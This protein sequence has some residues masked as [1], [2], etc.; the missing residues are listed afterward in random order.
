M[1]LQVGLIG[2]GN[3]SMLGGLVDAHPQAR[4]SAIYDPDPAA[5][6]RAGAAHP[7]A[8]LAASLDDLLS[9]PVD[10]VM[11][12]SPDHTHADIAVAAL[13]RGIPVFCEKPLAINA[14][15]ADRVLQAA[16]DH[17][18]RLY[19]GHNMR[20][21]PMVRTM[22]RLIRD[23]AIGEVKAIWCRHFVGNGGDYYFKDWHADR[24]NTTGLLLQKGAHDL[25]VIHW[26]AGGV[27][28]RVTALG[29]LAL[30]GEGSRSSLGD[31]RADEV[32]EPNLWP[33][34][35]LSRLHPVIDVEDISMML[36]ELDNGVM[37]SY[38]QCHFTPDYWRNYTVIGTHGRLENVGDTE[39]GEV[40]LWNRRHSGYAPPDEVHRFDGDSGNHGGADPPLIE[41]FVRYALHGHRTETSPLAAR[42]A[43]AAGE[44]ATRSLRSGGVP[45]DVTPP[46]PAVMAA[47]SAESSPW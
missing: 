5:L 33:P 43:V 4:V 31:Q 37:A 27:S 23:G 2:F 45:V 11:V 21:F 17:R 32:A 40:L 22:R 3:R 16:V 8:E 46:A 30:Y 36:M 39:T 47:F 35:D 15:D 20:H 7:G 29:K 14:T 25:D 18:A 9:G 10:A 38:Q 42:E 13:S 28:R 6:K 1:T 24:R 41:E 12:L 19:V 26:L 34:G 44:A